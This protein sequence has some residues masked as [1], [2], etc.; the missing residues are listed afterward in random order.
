MK[1]HNIR[2]G[3]ATN[4]SSS[5]SILILPRGMPI[6]GSDYSSGEYGWDHFVLAD[7]E[8]KLDY[9][10]LQYDYAL[11]RVAGFDRYIDHQSVWA[12]G[13]L[14]MT[15]RLTGHDIRSI[16][17]MNV[18]MDI[19][20]MDRVIILGG[21][22][23]ENSNPFKDR[24]IAQGASEIGTRY[25][26]WSAVTDPKGHYTLFNRCDGT[27]IR[28]AKSSAADP[29]KGTWPELVDIKITDYCQYGCKF[30]Y[31]NSSTKGQHAKLDT[32]LALAQRF[33]D[34]GVLEVALGGGE[35][36]THP[37]F[38]AIVDAFNS[39]N[40]VVNITSRNVPY[41]LTHTDL[42]VKA[43]A[44]SVDNAAQIRD[45]NDRFRVLDA[46]PR[47]E[48]HF[49]AVWGAIDPDELDRMMEA[50]ESNRLTLLGYKNAGRGALARSALPIHREPE[51]SSWIAPWVAR[52]RA[53]RENEGRLE[54]WRQRCSRELYTRSYYSASGASRERM[55]AKWES[56][57]PCP[58]PEYMPNIA[59]DTTLAALCKDELSKVGVPPLTYHTSEGAF[60]MYVDAVTESIGPSSY[61]PEHM[62]LLNITTIWED[63][64][65]LPTINGD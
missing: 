9:F 8:S 46:R 63:F 11:K 32:L 29:V 64:A 42:P 23:N 13:G 37:D 52:V 62:R 48:I 40:V 43:V 59:I 4:S 57:N 41:W 6:P 21:N 20:N 22:D 49:Q 60:S 30:C 54:G 39:A 51:Q 53:F 15:D 36:T 50:A 12:E 65:G 3:F 10:T 14:C 24:L 19:I 56:L 47:Y 2:L 5:H 61:S 28:L 27:K 1:I 34:S 55:V 38:A 7:P 18:L 31:Q 26:E 45:I 16:E 25:A 44:F 58:Q 33:R 17:I 35:P